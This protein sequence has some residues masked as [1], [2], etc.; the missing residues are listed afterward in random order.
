[1]LGTTVGA[2]MKVTTKVA[3]CS[4]VNKIMLTAILAEYK[5]EVAHS[6]LNVITVKELLGWLL[7]SAKLM[8]PL[9]Q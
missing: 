4:Y 1:M 6:T 9:G 3:M 7:K 2:I 5:L 8:S